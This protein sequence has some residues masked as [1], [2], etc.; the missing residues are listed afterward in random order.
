MDEI[1]SIEE[2]DTEAGKN[3]NRKKIQERL[4][5]LRLEIEASLS[6]IIV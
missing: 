3:E 2:E 5:Q 1:D 4:D 6:L